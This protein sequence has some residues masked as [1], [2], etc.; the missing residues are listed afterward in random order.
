MTDPAPSP[1][2]VVLHPA[3]AGADSKQPAPR[4]RAK[5]LARRARHYLGSLDGL[6]QRVP[7]VEDA[8]KFVVN[9]TVIAAAALALVV[10]VK[11]AVHPVTVI[12]AIGVPKELEE[13]GYTSAVVAQ[14]LLDE[15]MRIVTN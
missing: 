6:W 4:E 10:I 14:R 8:R 15:I 1:T 13:R 5:S 2:P 11:T 9:V 3:V 12:D 7:S